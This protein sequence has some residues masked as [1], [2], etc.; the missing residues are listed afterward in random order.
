MIIMARASPTDAGIAQQTT[1]GA[2]SSAFTGGNC[3]WD[4]TDTA[5]PFDWSKRF[6]GTAADAGDGGR[7]RRAGHPL[8]TGDGLH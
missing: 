5:T 4:W 6:D 2:A 1:R 7:Y 8:A 3:K